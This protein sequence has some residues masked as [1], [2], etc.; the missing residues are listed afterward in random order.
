MILR[1]IYTIF[2]GVLLATFVGVGITAFYPDPKSPEEPLE[3]KYCPQN[4]PTTP[5]LRAKQQEFD[6]AF[7]DFR[8]RQ[9]E[10]NKNVSIISV[11]AAIIILIVSL[12]LLKK[13]MLIADGLLLGGVLTLIYSIIRGFDSGDN[14]FRFIVVSI[15]LIIA[16]ILGYLKFIKLSKDK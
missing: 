2:I 15:G 10:Y 12:T 13:I 14:T 6:S 3:I 16:L 9:Q 8:N 1:I 5:E 7:K 4:E 11:A